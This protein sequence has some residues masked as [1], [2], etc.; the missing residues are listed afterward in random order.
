MEG[1]ISALKKVASVASVHLG[2]YRSCTSL[3]H[4]GGRRLLVGRL[5]W[6]GPVFIFAV[7]TLT[8]RQ[9]IL[10]SSI[11]LTYPMSQTPSTSMA[12][13]RSG[14]QTIFNAALK[15][16]QQKTKKDLIAH[17]LAEQLQ[18]CN[19]TTAILSILQE[20]VR[21]FD[22]AHS[23]DERLTRWLSP[24]VNVLCTFSAVVSG[25]VG[26]VSFDS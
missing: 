5:D 7:P 24:T 21:E 9:I 20:Q 16:Y 2:V 13:S 23:G 15:L 18:S 4:I 1:A 25:G 11:V 17:P 26:M 8:F 3:V 10:S 19:S 12:P 22:Q 14:F 6:T